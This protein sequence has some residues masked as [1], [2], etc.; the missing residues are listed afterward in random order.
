LSEVISVIS[1]AQFRNELLPTILQQCDSEKPVTREGFISVFQY[2]P[3]AWG[4]Q[5]AAYLH[6]VLPCV[7]RRLA[8]EIDFVR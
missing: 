5:F 8:D 2:I 7:T 6:L 4:V 1:E 3:S